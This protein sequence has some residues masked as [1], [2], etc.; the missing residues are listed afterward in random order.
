MAEPMFW[1]MQEA[2]HD[3]IP[4]EVS[5]PR[6]AQGAS[7]ALPRISSASGADGLEADR[8]QRLVSPLPCLSGGFY[9]KS[10][11]LPLVWSRAS[12]K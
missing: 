2:P 1:Q 11:L 10:H 4:A 3:Q 7:R 6:L 12:S 5:I 9:W 8:N